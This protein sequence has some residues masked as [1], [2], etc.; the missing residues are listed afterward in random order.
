MH[1]SL[2]ATVPGSLPLSCR[3]RMDC[4]G[5]CWSCR[6]C[7]ASN[8]SLR[9]NVCAAVDPGSSPASVV[10]ENRVPTPI[11]SGKAGAPAPRR[12]GGSD[13]DPE[14]EANRATDYETGPWSDE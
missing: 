2:L 9:V 5:F 12:D 3:F 6:G 11:K 4:M 1:F 13:A 14:A 7:I 8:S 10:D